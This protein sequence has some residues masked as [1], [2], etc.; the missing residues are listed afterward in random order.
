M[1]E[2]ITWRQPSAGWTV[3]R[4]SPLAG[5]AADSAHRSRTASRCAFGVASSV[6]ILGATIGNP[7]LGFLLLVIAEL[8]ILPSSDTAM[9]SRRASSPRPPAERHGAHRAQGVPH[10]RDGSLD[11]QAEYWN[12]P[13]SFARSA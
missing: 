11:D 6:A 7:G 10:A 9:D 5:P 8:I 12:R 13:I 2:N 4:P 3:G 1:S